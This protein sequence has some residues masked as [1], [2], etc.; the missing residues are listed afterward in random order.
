MGRASFLVG[1]D[2]GKKIGKATIFCSISNNYTPIKISE[3]NPPV[4]S[5]DGGQLLNHGGD[6]TI[7]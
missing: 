3:T 4:F 2:R 1:N 6:K 7:I 5:Q